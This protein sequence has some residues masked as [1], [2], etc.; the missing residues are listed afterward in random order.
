MN[1][2]DRK[3][4]EQEVNEMFKEHKTVQGV[5]EAL[6]IETGWDANTIRAAQEGRQKKQQI[7]E[8]K[9]AKREAK[10]K[11]KESPQALIRQ[12]AKEQKAE[13]IEDEKLVVA[14]EEP[15]TEAEVEGERTV[16]EVLAEYEEC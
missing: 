14:V 7:E 2:V 12:L 8:E 10:K 6:L 5:V 1:K 16:E 4:V 13:Q 15:E 11:K 9:E 3:I